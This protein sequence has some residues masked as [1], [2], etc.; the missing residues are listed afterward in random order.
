MV[1]L[2]FPKEMWDDAKLLPTLA[3]EGSCTALAWA[4]PCS[5]LSRAQ[6][7]RRTRGNGRVLGKTVTP[8]AHVI[9][10]LLL[11]A[12]RLYSCVFLI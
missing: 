6:S 8:E 2:T 1:L 5:P 10:L 12:F 4:H 9:S 3:P 7:T 11:L